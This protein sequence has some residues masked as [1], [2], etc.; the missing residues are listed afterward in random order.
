M[1]L[2]A[3]RLPYSAAGQKPNTNPGEVVEGSFRVWR[4]VLVG[5]SPRAGGATL[6]PSKYL[7]PGAMCS[8]DHLLWPGRGTRCCYITTALLRIATVTSAHKSMVQAK[9]HWRGL[10]PRHRCLSTGLFELLYNMV[11][12]FWEQAFLKTGSGKCPFLQ[13]MD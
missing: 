8:S 10:T 4:E 3:E 11:A 13:A 12:D 6:L 9:L 1:G 5:Q 7:I 2:F